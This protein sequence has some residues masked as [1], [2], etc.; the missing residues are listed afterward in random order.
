MPNVN[1][2]GASVLSSHVIRRARECIGQTNDVVDVPRW[3]RRSEL[4]SSFFG[5]VGIVLHM[6]SV[7]LG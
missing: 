3:T 4:G 1:I 2:L 6:K 5:Q 7:R